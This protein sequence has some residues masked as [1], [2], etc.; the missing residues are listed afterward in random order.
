MAKAK[1][2]GSLAELYIF[3]QINSAYIVKKSKPCPTGIPFRYRCYFDM[4]MPQPNPANPCA[5]KEITCKS[6]GNVLH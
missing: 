5:A 6:S 3:E 4:E 1:F 2:I